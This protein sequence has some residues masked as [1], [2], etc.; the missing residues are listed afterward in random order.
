MALTFGAPLTVPAGNVC[1]RASNTCMPVL[2]LPRHLGDHVDHVGIDLRLHEARHLNASHLADPRQVVSRKVDEHQVLCPL[3]LVVGEGVDELLH[4]SP[5][6][7]VFV[8]AMGFNVAM[9]SLTCRWI[10]GLDPTTV[11]AVVLEEIHV[12]RRIDLSQVPVELE[13][14]EPSASRKSDSTICM[15][16]PSAIISFAF[17]TLSTKGSLG[18]ARVRTGAVLAGMDGASAPISLLRPVQ[19][20]AISLYPSRG[21]APHIL[22]DSEIDFVRV[23]VVDAELFDEIEHAQHEPAP[24]ERLSQDPALADELEIEVADVS[25][26]E[27]AELSKGG[28]CPARATAEPRERAPEAP[29]R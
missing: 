29:V 8:P 4:M 14:L 2:E 10:S 5:G 11:R 15:A 22:R 1:L 17:L 26:G 19:L 21:S 13:R 25:A 20:A 7:R 18:M 16:S 27:I 24:G 23:V 9:R 6:A 28:S 12:R 3:L